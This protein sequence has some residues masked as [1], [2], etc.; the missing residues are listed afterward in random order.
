[1]KPEDSLQRSKIPPSNPTLNHFYPVHISKLY[2]FQIHFNIILPHET[3]YPKWPLSMRFSGQN[4]TCISHSSAH[5]TCL[6]CFISFA[7]I[8][9]TALGKGKYYAT[10]Q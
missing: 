7:V 8:P 9:L 2:Y 10:F 4:V 3:V 1:M 5:V 6:F